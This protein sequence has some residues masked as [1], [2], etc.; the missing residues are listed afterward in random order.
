[1]VLLNMKPEE[2]V[3]L[4]R[5]N[6]DKIVELNET[7][8]LPEI[9]ETLNIP[10]K[11]SR[12]YLIEMGYA[13]VRRSPYKG[14]RHTSVPDDMLKEIVQK[15]TDGE[16][17]LHIADDYPIE[18]S[19]LYAELKDKHPDLLS[20]KKSQISRDRMSESKRL[21][22]P[23][24]KIAEMYT[25]GKSSYEIARVFNTTPGTILSRLAEMDI[26]HNCQSIYWTEERKEIQRQKCYDGLIG[27]HAQGDDAYRFTK[28]ERE[29]AAWCDERNIP[30]TRQFQLEPGTHRY[31]FYLN[32][33]NIIV[34]IDGEYWHSSEEQ[35]IKDD[36][37]DLC[38][39]EAGYE[40]LRFTDKDIINTKGQCFEVSRII[41]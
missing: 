37:F 11:K 5:D 22:L 20:M 12:T 33:T 14:I 34:E 35:K 10:Y 6:F 1:M 27:I 16:S 38:A 19:R 32:G 31:D 28:P 29:F 41:S 26:E 15:I 9:C 39:K 40:V 2:H 30:Y 21:D 23:H 8:N 13:P 25:S 36:Y 24:D 17:L 18:Y 4:I 3:K 7:M